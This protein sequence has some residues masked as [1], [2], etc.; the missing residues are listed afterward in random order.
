LDGKNEAKL[1]D[2]GL[3]RIV[4]KDQDELGGVKVTSNAKHKE[5]HGDVTHALGTYRFAAPEQLA[6]KGRYGLKVDNFSCG[7]VLLEMFRDLNCT[8]M[9][10][11]AI[12]KRVR[13]EGKV[14]E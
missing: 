7:A 12:Y 2:F 1:G 10:M 14:Y 9:E 4:D 6:N 13:E 5:I 11:N 8:D 3:A